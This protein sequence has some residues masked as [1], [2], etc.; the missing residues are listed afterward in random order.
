MHAEE[1]KNAC[2]RTR[3]GET[4]YGQYEYVRISLGKST[5]V[6]VQSSQFAL[7]LVCRLLSPNWPWHVRE[8][9]NTLRYIFE[10]N[11]PVLKS[12]NSVMSTSRSSLGRNPS[13][14]F[15]TK[16]A[17]FCSFPLSPYRYCLP[18]IDIFW[19]NIVLGRKTCPLQPRWCSSESA[20]QF[21]RFSEYA[22]AQFRTSE[23]RI[24]HADIS[25]I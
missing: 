6:Y 19:L 4:C 25:N 9:A 15:P 14:H 11:R 24:F 8:L 3:F 7:S 23:T 1:S 21:N 18:L 10:G 13:C 20:A 5:N 22:V 17:N 2:N 12:S 16:C